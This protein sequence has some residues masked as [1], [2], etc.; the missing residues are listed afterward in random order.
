MKIAELRRELSHRLSLDIN[1]D[2]GTEESWNKLTEMLAENVN[3][4]IAFLNN[5]CTDEEFFWFSEEFSDVS[6]RVQSKELVDAMR[7]R[8]SRVTRETYDQASFK[9]EH[10]RKWVDYDEYVRSVGTEIDYAEGALNE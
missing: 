7:A 9:S 3:E 2:Y 1:D 8:L 6:E 4:T 5:E 10:I